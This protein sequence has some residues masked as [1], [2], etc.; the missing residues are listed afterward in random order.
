MDLGIQERIAVVTGASR[1]LGFAAARALGLE[2]CRVV[3]IARNAAAIHDAELRLKQ[4]GIDAVG[5]AAD[6]TDSSQVEAIFDQIR[7]SIGPPDILVYN[8]SGAR[9]LYYEEA[10]D[11]DFRD[12][13][14]KLIMGFV[15]CTRQVLPQMKDRGWGRIV[16]LG[17][18]CAREPHRELPMVLHNLGRPA[19]LGISKT[20]ANE[21]G[22][23][24]I[25]VNTIGI[26]M[27]DHDGEAVARSYNR[28]LTA[29]E[30][31]DFR[32]SANPVRRT[33]TAEELGAL[34]A[35]LCSE[36]AAFITGQMVLLDGGRVASLM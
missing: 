31:R 19:Q 15:W 28:N 27:I 34:A 18:L 33:G 3:V 36:P 13:F 22:Q 9:D 32:T 1:G 23:F 8:N 6:I 29:E 30:I 24:G 10:T 7:T 21:Y 12:A 16:T 35:F 2:G 5:I 11:E 4:E 17:S 25:T 14:E 26:G 20:L